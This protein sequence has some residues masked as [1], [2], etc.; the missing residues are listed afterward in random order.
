[1]HEAP[2]QPPSVQP[3]EPLNPEPGHRP[4]TSRPYASSR[5]DLVLFFGVLSLFLCGPLGIIAW[6]MGSSDLRRIR[7]GTMQPTKVGTLK[8]GRA[9]GIVG[10]IIFGVA[11]ALGVVVV[12]QG[13]QFSDWGMDGIDGFMRS[14]PLPAPEIAFAGEWHGEKG[15]LIRIRLDG[16]GD[17]KSRRTTLT[18][19]RVIIEANSL[20]IGLFGLEKTWRIEKRPYVIEGIWKMKL[21]GEEFTKKDQGLLVNRA[22]RTMVR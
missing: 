15:T 3:Q 11:I 4:G 5:A 20:S 9:L 8:V 19:G 1:M 13:V 7:A 21:D 17:F 18:G 14:K 2:N 10:T 16:S 12:K 22:R 6:I